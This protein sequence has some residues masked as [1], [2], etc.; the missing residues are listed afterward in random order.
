MTFK[1]YAAGT[2]KNRIS[3]TILLST[4]KIG[5]CW[6]TWEILWGKDRFTPSDLVL[7]T[8]HSNLELPNSYKCHAQ[9]K[10]SQMYLWQVYIKICLSIHAI[11]YKCIIFMRGFIKPFVN[12]QQAEWI[13]IRLHRC[14]GWSGFT[15]V[16]NAVILLILEHQSYEVN[17]RTLPAGAGHLSDFILF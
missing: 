14:S 7:W 3:E 10:L 9:G 15:L 8:Y 13:Q 6:V 4:H 11:W 16:A 2:Q 5:F 17:T 1:P 12:N